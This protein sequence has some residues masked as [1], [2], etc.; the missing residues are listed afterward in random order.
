M[1]NGCNN[2]AERP[3]VLSVVL[4]ILVLITG[5]VQPNTFRQR[6]RNTLLQAA[7]LGIRAGAQTILMLT[8]GIDLLD[9]DDCDCLV[10]V[11]ANQSPNGALVAILLGLVVGLVAG[12]ANGV[13]VALFRV[14]LLIMTPALSGILLGLFTAWT[15]TIRPVDPGRHRLCQAAW[16]RPS[17]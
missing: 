13:G 2:L 17:R 8:G 15:Q 16:C 14:N 3:A 4:I 7:P 1:L 6:A 5:A 12:S 9:H 11:A 10:Y